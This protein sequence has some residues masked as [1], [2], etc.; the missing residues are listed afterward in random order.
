MILDMQPIPNLHPIAVHRQRLVVP[1]I[2]DHQRDQLLRELIRPVVIGTAGDIDR[3]P[4]GLIIR[5]DQHVRA[6]LGCG[7]GAV[8]S[9][10]RGL[11]KHAG[12]PQRTVH[13]ICRHLEIPHALPIVL[14]MLVIG[15]TFPGGLCRLQ[16][17]MRTQNIR[18]QEHLRVRDAAVYMALRSEMDHCI[19]VI[20][21]E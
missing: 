10:R 4:E 5:P 11:C 18:G 14:G 12:F 9:Q 16:Q 1:G 19:K 13:L 20:F 21:L 17:G 15:F 8:G 6:G 2:V 3:Q 7:I